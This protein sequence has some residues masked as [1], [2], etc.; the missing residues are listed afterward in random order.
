MI[1]IC[2]MCHR[3][4]DGGSRSHYCPECLKKRHVE[5]SA[6]S[7]RKK[8]AKIDKRMLITSKDMADAL[9]FAIKYQGGE[10]ITITRMLADSILGELEG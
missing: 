3:K 9:R 5:I 8:D 10:E 7:Q 1:K 4:Y 2:K 6:E